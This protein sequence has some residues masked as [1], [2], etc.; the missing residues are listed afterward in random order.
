[1]KFE[2]ISPDLLGLGR[3]ITVQVT[4][5]V[6]RLKPVL[7]DSLNRVYNKLEKKHGNQWPTSGGLFGRSRNSRVLNVRTG[8]GLR[9]IKNSIRVKFTGN[10]GIQAEISAGELA[11][12]ET[13][14]TVTSRGKYMTIPTVFA[15]TG[16]GTPIRSSARRWDNTFIRESRAGNLFIFRRLG[17]KT[18]VPM[19]LL[20]TRVRIPARL[21][22]AK[23]IEQEVPIVEK[24]LLDALE[25]DT[26]RG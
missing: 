24:R 18:I 3:A 16:S 2:V 14:A 19:Y 15:M 13:G 9:S 10:Q 8:R 17:G 20:K 25:R 11:I 21:G 1:M 6:R 7:Q 12:H 5:G 4:S 23:A 22:L 26:R